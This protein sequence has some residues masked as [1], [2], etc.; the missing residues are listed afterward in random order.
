[1]LVPGGQSEMMESSSGDKDIRW[2]QIWIS[3][4]GSAHPYFSLVCCVLSS[5][6]RDHSLGVRQDGHPGTVVRQTHSLRF[7]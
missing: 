5:Q 7:S 6:D 3:A 2:G 4:G 1:M